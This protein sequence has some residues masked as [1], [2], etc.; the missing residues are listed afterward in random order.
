M[1]DAIIFEIHEVTQELSRKQ[2]SEMEEGLHCLGGYLTHDSRA[3]RTAA[4]QAMCQ[5]GVLNRGIAVQILQNLL[6]HSRPEGRAGAG[7]REV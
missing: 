4:T 7:R 2:P 5:I 6:A 3:L 1:V